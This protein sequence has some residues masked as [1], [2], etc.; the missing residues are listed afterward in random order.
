MKFYNALFIL[1]SIV[2]AQN[3]DY[4]KLDDDLSSTTISTYYS[5]PTVIDDKISSYGVIN[6]ITFSLIATGLLTNFL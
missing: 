4:P 5:Q 3:D 6:K 2:N 1:A